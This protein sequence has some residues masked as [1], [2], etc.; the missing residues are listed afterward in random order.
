MLTFQ[1]YTGFWWILS[2]HDFRKISFLKSDFSILPGH[3]PLSSII[4]NVIQVS[5][6]LDDL[7][8]KFGEGNQQ[9]NYGDNSWFPQQSKY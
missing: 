6:F 9:R 1:S 8:I 4:L 3:V 7:T 5:T 2:I